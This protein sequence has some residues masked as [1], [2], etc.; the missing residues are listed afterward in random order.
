MNYSGHDRAFQRQDVMAFVKKGFFLFRWTAETGP[1]RSGWVYV[2]RAA[3]TVTVVTTEGFEPT[4]QQAY[5]VCMC[6]CSLLLFPLSPWPVDPLISGPVGT[7]LGLT[8]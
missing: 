7:S 6:T 3:F 5:N 4:D 8:V 1:L 2:R